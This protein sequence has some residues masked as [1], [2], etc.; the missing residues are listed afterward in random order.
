MARRGFAND[1]ISRCETKPS[2]AWK[3]IEDTLVLG[4]SVGSRA[5]QINTS[6][7]PLLVPVQVTAGYLQ[8]PTAIKD[9]VNPNAF[10]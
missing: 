7:R 10:S 9:F 3:W 6:T 8:F 5:R 4:T 1:M 2:R